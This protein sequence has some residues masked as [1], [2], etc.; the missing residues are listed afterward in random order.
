M[1]F[2]R[3]RKDRQSDL[4]G[5]E[6]FGERTAR[7]RVPV[8]DLPTLGSE[9]EEADCGDGL[10]ALDLDVADREQRMVH[11]VAP[12]EVVLV[13]D[14]APVAVRGEEQSGVLD[15][16]TGQDHTRCVDRSG[17]AV[18]CSVLDSLDGTAALGPDQPGGRRRQLDPGQ[19]VGLEF[20]DQVDPESIAQSEAEPVCIEVIPESIG[21]TGGSDVGRWVVDLIADGEVPMRRGEPRSHVGVLDRPTGPRHP[22][23]LLEVLLVE[24]PV[25]EP[26]LGGLLP[27]RGLD[28]PGVGVP[29]PLTESVLDEV[30][31]VDRVADELAGGQRL[32]LR[33]VVGA[34]A[35]EQRHPDPSTDEFHGDDEACRA[36][37]DHTHRRGFR[38]GADPVVGGGGDE[39]RRG[40]GR[41]GCLGWSGCGSS[42][43]QSATSC[44][45]SRAR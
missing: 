32:Q 16:A 2:A 34:P 39:G 36:A 35:L 9:V 6:F 26:H 13:A 20:L 29:G 12:D 33:I 18:G 37:P 44:T 23:A 14:A 5:L 31:R 11:E 10:V 43:P 28:D 30:E 24:Q 41:H 45:R 38:Y 15:G 17:R 19:R 42:L 40:G 4:G 22:R 21:E 8:D 3:P 1:A 25:P 27:T 7:R